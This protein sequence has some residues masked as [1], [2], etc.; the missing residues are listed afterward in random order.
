PTHRP[1]QSHCDIVR[2][3]SRQSF[4][5]AGRGLDQKILVDFIAT[6]RRPLGVVPPHLAFPQFEMRRLLRLAPT[7]YALT[8][9]HGEVLGVR[10]L[11]I[12][13]LAAG[14]GLDVARELR[15]TPAGEVAT[16]SLTIFH[17]HD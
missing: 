6:P 5:D 16:A 14:R 9:S 1:P 4:V 17:D 11:D 13:V 8:T 15:N 3:R 2:L 10:V 7:G 12:L